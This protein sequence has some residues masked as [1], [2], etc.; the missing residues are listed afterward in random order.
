MVELDDHA[1]KNTEGHGAH[2]D[3]DTFRL[4]VL[5]VPPYLRVLEREKEGNASESLSL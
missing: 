4:R 1:Q 2:G 5:R 3:D